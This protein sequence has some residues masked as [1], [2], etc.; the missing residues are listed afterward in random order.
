M[1]IRKSPCASED[2][3][4][5]T[6]TSCLPDPVAS[7]SRRCTWALAPMPRSGRAQEFNRIR[8]IYDLKA[9]GRDVRTRR[10]ELRIADSGQTCVGTAR[11]S[12]AP[13]AC[14]SRF[15]KQTQL[16]GAKRAKQSQF[17]G[18]PAG[19]QGRLRETRPNLGRMEHLGERIRGRAQGK[20]AK[21]TQFPAGPVGTGPPAREPIVQDKANLPPRARKWSCEAGAGR[22]RRGDI[23]QNKPNSRPSDK[24]G[25]HQGR[26]PWRCH[27]AGELLRQTNPIWRC[28]LGDRDRMCETNPISAVAGGTWHGHPFGFALKAGSARES[29]PSAGCRCHGT[30]W[31]RHHQPVCAKQTKFR[32]RNRWGKP[33]PTGAVTVRNKPN[34]TGRIG[35]RRAKRAIQSQTWEDWGMWAKAASVC[36]TASAR[37]GTRKTPHCG[38]AAGLSCETKPIPGDRST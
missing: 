13:R 20:C 8:M 24:E 6:Q 34:S 17:G 15:Y 38:G 36:G 37:S 7:A 11:S 19:A 5:G 32:Q 4:E 2:G 33:H 12:L 14:A 18:S 30:A 29:G 23:V 22:S 9:E 16:A 25:H 26:R 35:P 3:R 27:P 10:V 1:R 28:A 31:R 21:Q